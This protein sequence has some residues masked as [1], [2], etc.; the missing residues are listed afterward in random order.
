MTTLSLILPEIGKPDKTEDPKLNTALTTV[1]TWANGG[2]GTSNLEA[3]LLAGSWEAPSLGAKVEESA[4]GQT[5][6]CRKENGGA[7]VRLRGA[8]KVRSG[9]T[10]SIGETVLTLPVGFRPPALVQCVA[11][12][13]ATATSFSIATSGVVTLAAS[14]AA[15]VEIALD[16][17]TF[18]IT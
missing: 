11:V 2:I 6:R 7:I 9:Q 10:L 17:I 5:V 14:T 12:T 4:A 16:N 18:N 15:T 13:S 3:G 1:Q 8:A